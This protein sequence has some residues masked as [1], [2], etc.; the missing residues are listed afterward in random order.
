MFSLVSDGLIYLSSQSFVSLIGLFWFTIVFEVP[1]YTIAFVSA[2]FVH[3]LRKPER[4]KPNGAQTVT[5]VVA[6]F[7]E[8]DS[9]RKCVLS[10]REQ[11]LPPDEIIVVSDGSTDDMSAVLAQL[12]REELITQAHCTDLRAGKAAATNMAVR[13]ASGDIIV[14][15]DCDCSYDR[16]ALKYVVAPFCDPEVGAVSGNI[17]VRNP[18]AGL[19]STFQ[20]IEYL[21]S[22]SLGKQA[23]NL[24]DQVV[25]A[26][27]AFGAFRRSAMDRVD[28]LDVG[29]GE[30]LDITMRM[31]KAGWRIEFADQALCYTDTPD[32]LKALT[33]Q[34][35][36]WERDAVRLRYRKHLDL[37]N[38]F[39]T[40]FRLSELLHQLEFIVFQIVGAAVMPIYIVWLFHTYGEM[41]LVFL[42][43]AQAGLAVLDTIVF[44]LAALATPKANSLSLVPYIFGYSLFN[45]V[46][47]RFVRLAAYLQEWI[48][49][50]S[51]NDNYVPEKVRI[52]RKW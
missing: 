30:D 2:A 26:S 35:F 4:R 9:I 52:L 48:F 28:G 3:G 33:S 43:A 7:N 47:M 15:V 31:R 45:G 39:S 32:T 34:R 8:E 1:R 25:C 21:I 20:A 17:L 42:V 27:G 37:L 6:G 44:A 18:D 19:I 24:I 22:I 5:V 23:A 40:G 49:N 29:G 14:N 41:G 51:A 10:L 12:Q 36:R 13:Y 11:S 50:A 38:P 46:Y 16:H